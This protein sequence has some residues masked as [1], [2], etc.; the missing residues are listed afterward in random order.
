M[1]VDQ[2]FEGYRTTYTVLGIQYP[3]IF[4]TEV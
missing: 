2:I 4:E 3:G 1:S